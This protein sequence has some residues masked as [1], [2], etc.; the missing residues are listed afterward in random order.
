VTFRVPP[1]DPLSSSLNIPAEGRWRHGPEYVHVRHQITDA[2]EE[3]DLNARADVEAVVAAG[4]YD[5]RHYVDFTGDGWIDPLVPE[6]AVSVPRRAA[7]Y[8][9]VTAPDF[10]TSCDQRELTEWA[11]SRVPSALRR[12]IWGV[13][14][15]PLSDQR[16]AANLQLDG[17][18][19]QADDDTVTAIVS[20]PV[21][22]TPRPTRL[23]VASTQRHSHLPDDAAG[24][25]APGW[26]AGV[27][28]RPGG[29][30]HLAAYGLGSPFPEDSKL[31]AALSSFWPAVAPD[32]TRTFEPSPRWATVIPLTDAE[33]GSEDDLPWDG[34][35]GPRLIE[36]EGRQVMDCASLANADYV[37]N[38]L[39]GRFSLS[40]TG[41]IAEHE[42]EARV[43]AMLRVYQVLGVDLSG[44]FDQVASR[45]A[46][47]AVLSFRTVGDGDGDLPGRREGSGK[48]EQAG[49]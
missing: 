19:F 35:P 36:H 28:G 2:G 42:Y 22:G 45:K 31:C 12:V 9:L 38:A 10:F 34:V 1:N 33:V 48:W 6:L 47:W 43:L 18:R 7:A 26:D 39:A 5:A 46:R 21:A 37:V 13:P 30:E 17:A 3:V 29:P 25:F 20:L 4:G 27:D 23:D 8:S 44:T 14:P 15:D 40:S 24:V 41:R 49:G 11:A 16:F 32:A